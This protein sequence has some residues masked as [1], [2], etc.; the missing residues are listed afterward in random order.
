M[1]CGTPKFL[2]RRYINRK[3]LI[4]RGYEIRQFSHEMTHPS[5][6]SFG[7]RLY[8]NP[9][10]SPWL[11]QYDST[12]GHPSSS[13]LRTTSTS[14]EVPTASVFNS[15]KSLAASYGS[16]RL[17]RLII[18]ADTAFFIQV[19]FKM[20][21]D[22]IKEVIDSGYAIACKKKHKRL[23]SYPATPRYQTG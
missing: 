2:K 15:R 14:R 17:S 23:D 10:Y 4:F 6:A 21:C 22:K 9:E 19:L 1:S 8:P 5:A 20:G 18:N 7:E 13:S 11:F 12:V 3:A 16:Y